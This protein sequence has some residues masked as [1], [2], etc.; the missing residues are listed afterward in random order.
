VPAAISGILMA[1]NAGPTS[2]SGGGTSISTT[3]P[4]H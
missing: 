4:L 2:D 3:E 1:V